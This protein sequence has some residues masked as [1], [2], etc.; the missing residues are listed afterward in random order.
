MTDRGFN[1]L[2][3]P[4]AGLVFRP[5]EELLLRASYSSAYKPPSL[6]QLNTGYVPSTVTISDPQRGGQS[7][8][9]ALVSG[10]NQSLKAE[11]GWSRT[12][13]AVFS[14]AAIPGLEVSLTNWAI[15]VNN[16]F[17]VPS[18]TQVVNFPAA[19]PG[20]V[21]RAA[22]TTGDP[23]SVGVITA[24]NTSY[25]NFGYIDEAGFDLGVNWK[26]ETSIGVFAPSLAITQTYRYLFEL[27]PAV[28]VQQALS[29]ANDSAQ[30]SPRWKGTLALN[31]S[32]SL[33]SLGLDGRYTGSYKDV[34]DLTTHP[35]TL[36]DF[37]YVDANVR[38][39]VGK[40]LMSGSRFLSQTS[41]SAGVRNLFN[42]MPSYSDYGSGYT[43][44]DFNEYDIEG[45][46]VWAQLSVRL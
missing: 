13:G 10:G 38:Y 26:Q 9:A 18:A 5:L 32:N 37:W 29:Q 27:N 20:R 16:G 35:R 25:A 40:S 3:S 44:Y 4:A 12:L 22:P 24:I 7:E 17:T 36:G 42:R 46:F 8:V 21:T 28:G 14:P 6:S 30:Y 45:R 1:D 23:Y 34:T 41:L 15:R 39:A 19:F 33:L 11:T 31:W 43:G 2:T